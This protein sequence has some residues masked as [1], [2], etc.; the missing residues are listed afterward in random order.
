MY[1]CVFLYRCT[2]KL[3]AGLWVDFVNVLTFRLTSAALTGGGVL[4]LL[5]HPGPQFLG[6][7]IG[8]G[9]RLIVSNVRYIDFKRFKY[10][11]SNVVHGVTVTELD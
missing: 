2:T 9:R 1:Q 8:G 6:P 3:H 4:G 5:Q 11:H 10:L 7:A